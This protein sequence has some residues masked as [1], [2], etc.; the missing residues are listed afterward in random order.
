MPARRK[1][2]VVAG[3]GMVAQRFLE[4]LVR[5]GGA[6][7]WRVTV[8]CEEPRPAY[9]RVAL[10]SFFTGATADDLSVAP[11]GFFADH[12]IE[13]RLGEG[14]A[15]IDRGRK[16]VTT[17]HHRDGREPGPVGRPAGGRPGGLVERRASLP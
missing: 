8:L 11:A 17:T 14:A 4:E 6:A 3:H 16:V 5:R 15:E 12:G 1:H 9:D 10:S 7:E 2:L 13:L